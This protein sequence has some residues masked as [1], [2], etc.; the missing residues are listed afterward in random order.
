MAVI[1]LVWA[2]GICISKDPASRNLSSPG[3]TRDVRCQEKL[4]PLV[5]DKDKRAYSV[6]LTKLNRTK[7]TKNKDFSSF[8]NFRLSYL[9]SWS[10]FLENIYI[11]RHGENKPTSYKYFLNI[12]HKSNQEINLISM[13][14][15]PVQQIPS[16]LLQLSGHQRILEIDIF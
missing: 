2:Q 1:V 12:R 16:L 8:C 13:F 3:R 10:S 14:E 6:L 11:T 5:I 7:V 15:S 9:A 4:Y